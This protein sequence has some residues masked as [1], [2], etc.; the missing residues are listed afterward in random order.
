MVSKTIELRK[1]ITGLL[2]QSNVD[3]YYENAIDTATFPYIVYNLESVNFG[4]TGRD[5]IYL[6]VDVWDRNTSSTNVEIISDYIEEILNSLN[7]PTSNVLPT[8]YKDSRRAL[9]DE[10]KTI[11]RRLL[12]FV[13]QNYYIGG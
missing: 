4:N 11:R 10:D 8:F 5:D 7:N 3:V 13:I 2:K 1:V 12:R 9:Q 6:E